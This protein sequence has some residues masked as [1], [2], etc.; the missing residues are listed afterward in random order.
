MM[1]ILRR[2]FFYIAAFFTAATINFFIPRLMPGNPVDVMFAKMNSSLPPEAK[3]ALIETFGFASGP[4]YLQFFDYIKSVFTWNLGPS[5]KFYPLTVGQVLGH[6]LPWTITLAGTASVLAFLSGSLLGVSA[7]WRRGGILDT[8]ASPGALAIQSIPAVVVALTVLYVF[9]LILAWFP[10]SFAFD[11]QLD[12][13]LTPSFLSSALYHAVMPVVSLAFVHIGGYLVTMR[14]NMIGQLGEDYVVMGQAKGL[15]D[16]RVMFN[17]AA[18][19]AL[20]PSVTAFAITLGAVMGGSLVTEVV[21]NYPGLGHLLYLGIVARDYPLIQGQLLIMTLAM[22]SAN[23]LVDLIYVLLD[24][25]LRK[26]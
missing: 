18:R 24:P 17:Y 26:A 12:P 10:T 1:F 19:N 16:R 9:G 13:G 5:I 4:L 2:L 23:L 25:R 15:S 22:L 8:I 14:N 3:T 21:F 11:P 20:L 6:A 7:A